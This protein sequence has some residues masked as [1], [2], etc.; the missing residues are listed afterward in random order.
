ME[1]FWFFG[2][3]SE[4]RKGHYLFTP[5]KQLYK[6]D[7]RMGFPLWLLDGTFQPIEEVAGN[8]RLITIHARE[9]KML[10]ILAGWD[11]TAD[12]RPGSNAAFIS[13][14]VRTLDEMIALAKKFFPAQWKRVAEG[15]QKFNLVDR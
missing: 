7:E 9:H 11:N 5:W 4:D 14:K 12:K 10:T 6:D 2:C 13:H 8:W 3:E 15:E 1:D